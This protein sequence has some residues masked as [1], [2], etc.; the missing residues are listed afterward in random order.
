MIKKKKC[1]T[2]GVL[3]NVVK[4]KKKGMNRSLT[5]KKC[6]LKAK[7]R[8]KSDRV[9]ESLQERIKAPDCPLRIENQMRPIK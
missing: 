3:K 6:L 1:T 4:F 9:F 7:Y 5:C 2:C 8:K